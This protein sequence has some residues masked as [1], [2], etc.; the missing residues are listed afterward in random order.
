VNCD[1]FTTGLL[2]AIF[3]AVVWDGLMTRR[4]LAHSRRELEEIEKQRA[5][6]QRALAG[7]SERRKT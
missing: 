5:D 6:I 2:L 4:W 3:V 1:Y 7:N